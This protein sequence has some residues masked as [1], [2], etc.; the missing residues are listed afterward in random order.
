[1]RFRNMLLAAI[2]TTAVAGAAFA[3]TDK[4]AYEHDSAKPA[5]SKAS[6]DAANPQIAAKDLKQRLDGGEKIAILDARH[7]LGGQILKGAIHVPSDKLEEWAKDVD[8]NAVIVTYCT[9]PHDEAADGEVRKLRE[10]GFKNAYALSGGLDAARSAGF[11][12]VTPA[13]K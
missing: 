1:M 3:Q 12:V 11:E 9:C 8:K 5:D 13:D 7:D 6:I 4:H 10:M 2:V